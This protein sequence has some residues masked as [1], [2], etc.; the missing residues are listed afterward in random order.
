MKVSSFG[1]IAC[2]LIVSVSYLL[3]MAYSIVIS[4]ENF[5]SERRKILELIGEKN[6]FTKNVRIKFL[7]S[8]FFLNY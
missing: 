4:G 5:S 6:K 1:F 8:L 2:N 7:T 3:F